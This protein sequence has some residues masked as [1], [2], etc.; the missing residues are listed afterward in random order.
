MIGFDGSWRIREIFSRNVPVGL[1][2][3]SGQL[4]TLVADAPRPTRPAAVPPPPRAPAAVEE[5]EDEQER[6]EERDLER[7]QDTGDDGD[8]GD[9]HRD[10]HVLLREGPLPGH[11]RGRP[12]LTERRLGLR[13]VPEQ[14]EQLTP[15]L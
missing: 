3:W 13:Q 15:R 1:R 12:R 10:R 2:R 4:A 9:G 7:D 11:G 8:R 14:P 5:Q 6:Q